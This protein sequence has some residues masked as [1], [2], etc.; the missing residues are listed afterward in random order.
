MRRVIVWVVRPVMI[1]TIEVVLR[2]VMLLLLLISVA[3]VVVV[4]VI[5]AFPVFV[6]FHWQAMSSCV[7]LVEIHDNSVLGTT[8]EFIALLKRSYRSREPGGTTRSVCCDAKTN[9]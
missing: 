1:L 2:N 5:S 6:A 7:A 8:V 9:Y 3:F 4:A